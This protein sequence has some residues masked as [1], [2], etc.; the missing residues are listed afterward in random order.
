MIEQTVITLILVLSRIGSFLVAAP[1][2]GG[3]FAPRMVKIGLVFAL[4]VMWMGSGTVE[5]VNQDSTAVIGWLG[6]GIAT[7]RECVLGATIGYCFGLLLE[8]ARIAGAYIGQEM[9]LTLATV[10][11]P[12]QNTSSNVFG[13][14]LETIAILLCLGADTH[15]IVLVGLHMTFELWPCGS[16]LP[17]LP[18]LEIVHD[19]S[20]IHQWG[21]LIAAP[22]GICT[23]L[24]LIILALTM[25]TSP[26][27]NLFSVGFSVRL[28][29]GL[30]AMFVLI[31]VC[32]HAIMRVLL[33]AD[34][35]IERM[36][37]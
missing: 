3:G 26:Q 17:H 30:V 12:G 10:V 28:A 7:V 20:A 32:L 24:T 8:P 16:P 2:Y 13:Q 31:P 14:L 33:Q 21:L 22:V 15:L 27:L 23:F 19:T 29:A 9:G 4:A 1:V 18:L 37:F 5:P 11:D 36:V 35:I 6:L 25:K 34:V